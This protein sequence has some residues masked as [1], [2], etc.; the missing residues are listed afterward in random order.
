M[1]SEKK[2][3]SEPLLLLKNTDD[4][5]VID[6]L[7]IWD[8]QAFKNSDFS[9]FN[10]EGYPELVSECFDDVELLLDSKINQIEKFVQEKNEKDL[11]TEYSFIHAE[12]DWKIKTQR[13]KKQI[14]TDKGQNYLIASVDAKISELKGELRDILD[15]RKKSKNV[16]FK[17]CGPLNIALLIPETEEYKSG[18]G[19]QSIEAFLKLQQL[20]REIELKGMELVIKHEV[21]HGRK[22]EDVSAEMYLGYDI[23]SKSKNE[24]RYIEV[25][26]FS[27]ENP[28][29]I[30]SNE[31]RMSSHFREDYYLYIIQHVSGEPK[32]TIIRDPY[33]NISKYVNKV[34]IKDFKIILKKLDNGIPTLCE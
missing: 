10:L 9:N 34:E 30:S 23:I 16:S 18:S 2:S 1:G 15:K 8:L 28:I 7:S 33:E 5:K 31:W 25:K 20:K 13:K 26:S 22:P 32:L 17:V 14:Y 19:T 11:E 4:V 6:S 29:E 21:E 12:Y 3:Y 24:T 27:T